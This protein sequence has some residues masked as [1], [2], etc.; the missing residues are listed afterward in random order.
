MKKIKFIFSL[1]ILV[2]LSNKSY[3]VDTTGE[4]TSY[5]I[6]MTYLELCADGSS[7]STCSDPLVVG[8]GDSGAI[9]IAATTA[10]VAA[11][12]YGDFTTVPFGKSY[13]YFK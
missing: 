1:L 12:S 5:K 2:F 4:A 13:T 6:T 8:S 9:D 3:A 11:A 10:G 7:T